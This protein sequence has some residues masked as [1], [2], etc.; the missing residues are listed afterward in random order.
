MISI[1]IFLGSFD[2]IIFGYL[3]IIKRGVKVFDEVYV[4]VL[5]NLLKKLFFL[6][7]E[8]LE[9]IWEVIKDILNVKVDLYS[10]LLVEYV[11]MCNVNVILCGLWVVFDFE[12]EM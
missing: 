2:L 6:V 12:Y 5:N 3:D 9:L 7:E 10:G 8:W 11:K 4:V 1:V